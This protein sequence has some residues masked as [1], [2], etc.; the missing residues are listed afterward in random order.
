MNYL[1]HFF[2]SQGK[3]DIVAGNFLGDFVKGN[4]HLLLPE[5]V[6]NGVLL[7]RFIDDYTDTSEL[8]QSTRDMLRPHCGKYGG[9]AMDLIHDRC[10]AMT[11][12]EWTKEPL[13]TFVDWSY[14]CIEERRYMMNPKA[15]KTFD[16]MKSMNWLGNYQ[17]HSG[18]EKSC[19][20]LARR[21]PYKS[22]LEGVPELFKEQS[23]WFI[24]EFRAFFPHIQG[25]CS[26]KYASFVRT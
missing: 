14:A 25:A 13:E 16:A 8:N 2:L 24:D 19:K 26:E 12:H 9:V 1:A 21:I 6:K 7:H 18:F 20:G 22:G 5:E 3:S 15:M 17:H 23:E 4:K 10:L 11:W